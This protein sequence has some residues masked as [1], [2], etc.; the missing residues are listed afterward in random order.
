[1]PRC[2]CEQM[3]LPGNA[4]TLVW[5]RAADEL[6]EHVGLQGWTRKLYQDGGRG[7]WSS[8][9]RGPATAAKVAVGDHGHSAWAD[10][11]LE[12]VFNKHGSAAV[13]RLLR[14][15]KAPE[16]IAD[17]AMNQPDSQDLRERFDAAS[18]PVRAR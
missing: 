1:M 7:V 3:V 8:V 9:L 17:L 15:A 13:A 18:R 14:E 12:F 4:A 2:R 16:D 11:M 10:L 6:E 5:E